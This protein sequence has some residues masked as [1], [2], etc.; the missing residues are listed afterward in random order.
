MPSRFQSLLL[1][2]SF[3]AQPSELPA[4]S[5]RVAH[6]VIEAA[7]PEMPRADT[8]STVEVAEGRLLTVYQKYEPGERSGNDEGYCRIWSKT[9]ADGGHSWG[10]ARMLVD[11]APGDVNVMNAML[12]K[13]SPR[14]ILLVCH[15]YHP[16]KPSTSTAELWRSTDGGQTFQQE[17]IV[18]QRP[19]SYRVA[20]PP[21]N[22]LRS[23][24][25]VLPFAAKGSRFAENYAILTAYSDDHGATWHES[26]HA[27]KLAKRGAMEPSVAQLS[28]GS[29]VMAIR[30]QLGGPYIARSQDDGIT[31]TEAEFSGLEGGE[32]GT[33]LRRIPGTDRLVLF[34]NN[35]KYV[36]RGH[37]HYGE[38]T[39]L[40]AAVSDDGG[41]SWQII[42]QLASDPEAEYT[43]LE[44]L[45]TSHGHAILTY[46]HAKPAWNRNR[47]DLRAALIDNAW[48]GI[49]EDGAAVERP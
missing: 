9:S 48:F 34:F 32:S 10:N 49:T 5:P 2:V 44:C 1:V 26:D 17:T 8:A 12:L 40:S 6:V 23:G 45:F 37:H 24:R 39:P 41:Q 27:I 36:P 35:S 47:I 43:N 14:E 18:W 29:L 7:R 42:G 3:L 31:W 19:R 28:D 13:L 20:I 38:R 33:C 46:M 21:L 16:P 30:T 11:V 4:E 22:Q 15:R 25:I